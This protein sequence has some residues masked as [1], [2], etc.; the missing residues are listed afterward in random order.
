M[1][2]VVQSYRVTGYLTYLLTYLPRRNGRYETKMLTCL[3]CFN[4]CD[5]LLVLQH[6]QSNV[7]FMLLLHLCQS[8]LQLLLQVRKF[9]L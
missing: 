7:V 5:S 8:V 4:A 1:N 6:H 2:K 3:N 9:P